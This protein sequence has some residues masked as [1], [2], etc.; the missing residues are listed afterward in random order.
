M[1]L[2]GHRPE[3]RHLPE[4]PL[5]DAAAVA[6]PGRQIPADLF[7]E[8]DKNRTAFENRY[9]RPAILRR[10]INNRRN[11]IVRQYCEEFRRE[12]C[13]L[14][15]IDRHDPVRKLRLFEKDCD[16]VAVRRCP[17]MKVDHCFPLFFMRRGWS[18]SASAGRTTP[19]STLRLGFVRASTRTPSSTPKRSLAIS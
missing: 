8:I 1:V 15:D 10:T 3:A 19:S 5:H 11:A 17:I 14:A 16:L 12:L 13:A 2:A 9:R 6:K 4:Q 18:S 7:G